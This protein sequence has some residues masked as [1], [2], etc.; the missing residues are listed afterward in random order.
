MTSNLDQTL[1]ITGAGGFVGR[2]LLHHVTSQD[3]PPERL[4]AVDLQPGQDDSLTMWRQCD[5]TCREAVRHLLEE[6]Q[7]TAMIHLAGVTQ[8]ANLD[9][10]FA[11]NVLAC[12][13]LLSAAT[14][15]D[16]PPR[17]LVVG[18]AAQYGITAGEHEIVREDRSLDAVTPYGVSKCMQEQWALL[19]GRSLNLPVLCVRPFNIM[20]S[21]QGSH[22]IPAAFLHQVLQV[23]QG[24]ASEVSVGNTSTQ[25]DF[26]DVRDVAAAFWALLHAPE[27]ANRRVYNI[28]SGQAV[29]VQDILDECI[30]LS[31]HDIPVRPDPA[32]MKKY[33]VPVIV[34]D[35]S[36][37]QQAVDW[38]P[39]IPWRQS[40]ADMWRDMQQQSP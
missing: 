22:L 34:G 24:R 37:L 21:G 11:A 20:G 12:R 39:R 30:R 28:A 7:P 6:I 18:S 4:V 33:D 38:R 2:H 26:L 23:L 3:H 9:V 36:R 25:R 13:N 17:T 40:V 29:R 31:G 19:A 32:R 27:D 15:L 16:R 35:I 14:D 1:L 5:L 8:H 10:V